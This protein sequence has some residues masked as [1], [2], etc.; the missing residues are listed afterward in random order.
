MH[1]LPYRPHSQG[2]VERLHR[3]IQKGLICFKLEKKKGYNIDYSLSEIIKIKNN[4]I[5]RTIKSTPNNIFFKEFNEQEIKKINELMLDSQKTSNVYRNTFKVNEK[6]LINDNFNLKNNTIKRNERKYGKWDING[7]IV[8]EY[9]F[10]S[11]KVKVT[12]NYKNILKKEECYYIHCTM[13]KKIDPD[14]WK[15]I[16]EEQQNFIDGYLKNIYGNN[17]DSNDYYY[18][19]ADNSSISGSDFGICEDENDILERINNK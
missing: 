4:T 8:K 12:N 15:K 2:V 1:G 6:V 18:S 11:Y 16:N 7:I 17:K 3:V 10:N 9:S 5:C 14:V 13:L 19:S